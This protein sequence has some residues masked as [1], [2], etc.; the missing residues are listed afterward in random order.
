MNDPSSFTKN[1]L[2]EVLTPQGCGNSEINIDVYEE[3]VNIL[4]NLINKAKSLLFNNK[5]KTKNILKK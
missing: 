3:E 5:N 1:D 2:G 4:D